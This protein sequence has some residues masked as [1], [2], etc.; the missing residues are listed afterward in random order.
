MNMSSDLASTSEAAT[1][2]AAEIRGKNGQIATRVLG[3]HVKDE[4]LFEWSCK[5]CHEDDGLHLS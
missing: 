5:F 4:P 1:I 3:S 2:L